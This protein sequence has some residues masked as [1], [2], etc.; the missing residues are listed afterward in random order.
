LCVVYPFNKEILRLFDPTEAREI[1]V[2]II[3][4]TAKVLKA[5]ALITKDKEIV[6]LKE[7]NT[8]WD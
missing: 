6:E 7:V 1:Y 3:V 2:K 8:I 5:H 4:L